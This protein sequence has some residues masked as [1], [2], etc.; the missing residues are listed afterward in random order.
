GNFQGGI[1]NTTIKSGTN[2]FH[3]DA[4]EF[5]RN[6]VL[7]ANSWENKFLGPGHGV[8]RAK[9]RWNM[10]GGTIGGPIIKNK[11]FFFG[12]YQGQRFDH[13]STGQFISVFT[14]AERGGDFGALCKGFDS[15]G[16]CMDR[17][18]K[19][20]VINQ[21]YNP[22]TGVTRPCVFNTGTR[23]F[24]PFNR[25][26]LSMIDPVAQNLFN[27]SVY[28][29]PINGSQTNN[30]LNTQAQAFNNNQFDVKIDFNATQKDHVFGR[31]T[32]AHQENPL[33][34]SL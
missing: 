13:P 12:D 6:D 23:A 32:W 31:Y 18:S 4:W 20:Q 19:G 21:L 7:N 11:L 5:F 26:P 17:N 30:A 33:T 22:C 15:A 25:I 2:S 29:T 3:G 34:N 28:P 9:L 27:S 1:V 16:L 14:A 10:F 8:P 24:F